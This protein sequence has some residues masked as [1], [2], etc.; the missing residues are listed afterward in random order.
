[1]TVYNSNLVF[2]HGVIYILLLNLLSK[3][4]RINKKNK[5]T[6]NYLTNFTISRLNFLKK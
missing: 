5:Q 4:E 3:N 1:M 6:K 2:N